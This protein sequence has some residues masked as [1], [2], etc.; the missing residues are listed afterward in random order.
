MSVGS[1]TDAG[2][3][4]I[5]L[6]NY[7]PYDDVPVIYNQWKYD[8]VKFVSD[9]GIMTGI[10]GTAHF[11]PDSNLTRAQFATILYRM[12]GEPYVTYQNVFSDTESG[13]WYSDGVIWAY[14]SGIVSGFSDGR[15]G[16]NDYITREQIAKMLY[17][18]ARS[19]KGYDTSASASLDSF[20]DPDMVNGWARPYVMWAVGSKMIGGKPNG[21]GSFRIDPKGNATRAEA[22][23]MIRMFSQYYAY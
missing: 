1:S 22:A 11:D 5:Q 13:K 4:S 9:Q 14:E 15:F 10:S 18:Y 17:L 16:I 7:F 3:Y 12:A 21:D 19:V 2:K 23:K 6:S 8:S 20:T